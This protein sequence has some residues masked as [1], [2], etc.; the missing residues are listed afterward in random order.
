MLST[1]GVPSMPATILSTLSSISLRPVD[2]LLRLPV[3]MAACSSTSTPQ[4]RYETEIVHPD[5]QLSFFGLCRDGI[6]LSA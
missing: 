3:K 6:N 4:L 2:C 5:D 1:M